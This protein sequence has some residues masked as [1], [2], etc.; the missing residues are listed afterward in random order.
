MKYCRQ[1]W[2]C[3]LATALTVTAWLVLAFTSC[4]PVTEQADPNASITIDFKTQ[5]QRHI[6]DLQDH[7]EI[8]SLL[9]YLDDPQPEF[10]YLAARAFGSIISDS[11][12]APL[13]RLLLDPI[14]QIRA[15]A[16]YALGQQGQ[17]RAQGALLQAFDF[18]DTSGT[19]A[20][21]NAAILEAIGKVGDTTMLN[22]LS[23][24]STYLPTDTLLLLGQARG[25][26]RLGTRK[27]TS[28]AATALM[29]DRALSSTWPK[30]VRVLAAHYLQRCSETLDGYGLSIIGRLAIEKEVGIRIP[31][32]RSLGKTSDPGVTEG[33]LSRYR[34]ESDALV[35]VEILR[36]LAKHPYEKTREVLLEAVKD[37]NFMIAETAG[38]VLLSS[39]VPADATQYWQLAKDTTAALASS[40][41]YAAA[42]HH[43]PV[44]LQDYRSYINTEMRRRFSESENDYEKA[45]IL[46]AMAEYPWNFRFLIEQ[47]LSQQKNVVSTSAA[48]AIDL[49][50]AE[51]TSV[52]Y[53]RSNFPAVKR[54]LADY[55]RAVFA[56]D[57][58]GLQ[59]TAAGTIARKEWNFQTEYTSLDFLDNAKRRLTLPRDT[60]TA[61]LIEDAKAALISG[62]IAEKPEPGFNHP[63][64]WDIYRSLQPDLEV[65]VETPRGTILI[66]FLEDVSPGTVVNFVQTVR[67]GF[68]NGKIFHRV[69]PAFVTQGGCPRGDGYGSLDY[70]LRTETPQVYY[71]APGYVG[72][73][74]AGR[75][76]EGV[77]FF[78][79][80]QATPHLDGRYTIFGRVT[81]GMDVVKNLQRG[82]EMRMKLR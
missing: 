71:D 34:E 24:I 43:L 66:D 42:L 5:E 20:R 50:V 25:L 51:P 23:S 60:E 56:G 29:I 68:Y 38:E 28:P 70:S 76:T 2:T 41:L 47:A 72:M 30:E 63:I 44:F 36:A 80:H 3:W 37:R 16:A 74:S 35:R 48:E 55:F 67:N 52:A 45:A 33:L 64:N 69:V 32:S 22:A 58:P 15:T 62:Y 46:R 78:F 27:I 79:T 12:V 77:Q 82:D 49:I 65:V 19:Y 4:V 57:N 53:F 8:D 59:A 26:Y 11:S 75:H 13:S 7:L 54:E 81:Q 1:S 21:S 6:Y 18:R 73:A 40:Q 61:Y 31:L 9:A 14:D 39:G 10:R 17:A